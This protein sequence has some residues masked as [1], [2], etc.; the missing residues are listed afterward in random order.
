MRSLPAMLVLLGAAARLQESGPEPARAP[1]EEALEAA[2]EWIRETASPLATV[3]PG[4]GFDDLAPFGAL[5]EG[6]RL[7]GL[8]EATHGSRELFTLKHRLFEYLVGEHGFSVL[9][10]EASFAECVAID[11]YVRTGEG[12]AAAVLHGQRFWT[13]DTEEV[14]D[15]V[16]WMRRFNADPER[17]RELRVVGVDVQFPA[18][19]V[20]VALGA[21]EGELSAEGVASLAARLAPLRREDIRMTYGD[22]AEATRTELTEACH[23][24]LRLLEGADPFTHRHARVLE[25]FDRLLRSTSGVLRDE[26]MAENLSWVLEHGGAD[27]RAVFWGHNGHVMQPS[28]M[29]PTGS[30]LAARLGHGY[31]AVGTSFHRGAFQA[32]AFLGPEVQDG[33]SSLQVHEVGPPRSGSIGDVLQRAGEP[34]FLLDLTRAPESGPIRSWLETWRPVRS[35]GS[36]Y[37]PAGD[38]GSY[39]QNSLLECWDG[40]VFVEHTSP[41]RPNPLTRE[42][43]GLEA[44]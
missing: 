2:V 6:A 33:V 14:L 27:V 44:D 24:L 7:V 5:V 13:L 41:A 15:L 1:E 3:E 28:G 43:F 21:L 38:A 40:I 23:E 32:R 4:H 26:L 20:E 11:R 22:L 34:L 39:Q 30:S 25:Q 8:G 12:D 42:R 16:R 31:V 35:I 29:W 37:D 36:V 19:A 17:A 18:R 10:L 9:A